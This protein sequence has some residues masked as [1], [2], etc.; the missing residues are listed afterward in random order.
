MKLRLIFLMFI[1][2][3][4]FAESLPERIDEFVRLFD[5]QNATV[6]YDIRT[7]E[8]DYPTR[9]LTPESLL[10]QTAN[11]P[12]KDIQQLYKLAVNCTGSIPL[13]PLI[14]EPL[15]FTRAM[16]NGTKLTARWFARSSMI[17]PGGGSYAERYIA[18][19]PDT[20]EQLLKYTHIQERPTRPVTTLLGR[21]QRMEYT[22]INAL[23]GGATMFSSNNE[24]WL[25]KGDRYFIFNEK[26]WTDKAD[27]VGLSYSFA[28]DHT[29]CFVQRGNLCWNLKDQSELLRYIMVGLVVV[30]FLLIISWFIYRGN[31][32]RKE[33][34]S[35][36]LV[37]QILTHELRTPIASLS[38]T[39][40]GFRREFEVLPES[41][42]EEFRRLCEDSRRLRQ[43]AE[44]SKDYLQSDNQSLAADWVP[45]IQEWLEFKVAEE[46]KEDIELV[47]NQ[48]IAAKLNVY[49]L[50][51]CIDNLLRNAFKYGVAPVK[52][53][54]ITSRDSVIFKVIDQG[55]LNRKHWRKLRKA[56]VSESGLGLGLTIVESM[57]GRMGGSMSLIG[58]PSTFILEIPCETDVASS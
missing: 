41:L 54:V 38:L 47:I 52:L 55:C 13:S 28:K 7:I 24:F 44:A 10:P 35:R 22:A 39:V 49:W 5:Y 40:E 46:F 32:K 51:T 1:S 11:Y 42:Y 33:L 58:P 16:C 14:T 37:L 20:R 17:H 43:L 8:A 3:N 45:S 27:S 36:M 12:I 50:W 31:S 34:K 6:T 26:L 18:V 48:D 2:A 29:T 30:N 21:L 53:E 15:V 56:F 25:R 9:L 19:H 23:L 57:V 4:V